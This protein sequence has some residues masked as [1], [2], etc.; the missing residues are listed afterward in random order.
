[1]LRIP[2]IPICGKLDKDQ[3]LSQAVTREMIEEVG[4]FATPIKQ[5]VFFDSDITTN[6]KY[7]GLAYIQ[8]A[9]LFSS[10]SNK[11]RISKEH[12]NYKWVTFN[13]A[14]KLDLTEFTRKALLAWEADIERF[15]KKRK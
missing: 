13:N 1:M 4:L 9:G 12:R 3:D 7:K 11:V 15:V 5:L 2:I 10:E 6:K 14:L 8:L